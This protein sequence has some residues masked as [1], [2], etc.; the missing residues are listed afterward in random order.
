MFTEKAR[1]YV[2]KGPTFNCRMPIFPAAQDLKS[3]VGVKTGLLGLEFGREL[4]YF[5]EEGALRKDGPVLHGRATNAYTT[6]TGDTQVFL[7]T[8]GTPERPLALARHRGDL[9]EIFWYDTY[10]QLPF[11]P[12]LFAVPEGVEV[13][14]VRQ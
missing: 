14:D 5:R 2:D 8:T 9:R 11:D 7:F 1:H 12:R 13:R 6:G 3:S 10:E 4:G